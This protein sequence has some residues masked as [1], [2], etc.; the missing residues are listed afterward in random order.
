M[1]KKNSVPAQARQTTIRELLA[2]QESLKISELACRFKVTEMTIHRD[3]AKLEQA[4]AVRKTHGGVVAAERMIFEFDFAAR[5]KAN[6]KAKQAIAREAIKL[7]RP[8]SRLILDTGTTTLELAYLLKGYQNITV[9][10]PSLAVASVLQFSAG[11]QTILLGGS[12]CE[13]SPDLTG[14][15]TEA[16]L[17]TLAADIAFQG[18]DGIGEDGM[19]YNADTRIAR[20][21]QKIRGRAKHTY[22]LS[23][24]SK[25]GKTALAGSGFVNEVD[26][27]IT[28]SKI[29]Q[30]QLAGLK[31]IGSKVI[32][33][34][35]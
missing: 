5:R 25:I 33:C 10:T 27:L 28:D 16:T 26:S 15:I 18:A 34:E 22:I 19:L 35:I 32:I 3:L 6:L 1:A 29:T 20:V 17:D 7:V 21:D 23:D 11:V 2:K 24:S 13:G 4:N 30:A 9:I 31:K 12:I 14:A 8:G